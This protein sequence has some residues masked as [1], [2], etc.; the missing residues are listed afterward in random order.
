MAQCLACDSNGNDPCTPDSKFQKGFD[1]LER[2][3]TM[4]KKTQKLEKN[5]KKMKRK[6]KNHRKNYESSDSDRSDPE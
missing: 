2:F 4:S 1:K 6:S 5:L 3:A